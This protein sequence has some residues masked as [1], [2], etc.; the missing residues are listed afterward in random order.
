MKTDKKFAAEGGKR[1]ERPQLDAQNMRRSS[2]ESR[3]RKRKPF[4]RS[5]ATIFFSYHSLTACT[6]LF[7]TAGS[8]HSPS[9]EQLS[10]SAGRTKFPP[11]SRPA[12]RPCARMCSML[13]NAS[14]V[15]MMSACRDDERSKERN[16]HAARDARARARNRSVS[17]EV[18]PCHLRII[19]SNTYQYIVTAFS[20]YVH[21]ARDS[22]SLCPLASQSPRM[23]R[24][25]IPQPLVLPRGLQHILSRREALW[26]CLRRK[27]APPHQLLDLD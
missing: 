27:L 17:F 15:M 18:R 21:V 20:G 5:D 24:Q 10:A 3:Q 22:G 16:T 12:G 19:Y 23:G 9:I 26:I 6:S 11:A 4:A 1:A 25:E 2:A 8:I 7:R 13:A 14:H